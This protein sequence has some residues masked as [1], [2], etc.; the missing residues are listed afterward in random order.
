[1]KKLF[2]CVLVIAYTLQGCSK[3]DPQTEGNTTELSSEKEIL[4]FT[5]DNLEVILNG[6]EIEIKVPSYQKDFAFIPDYKI[7][8]KAT[9][10]P[11]PTSVDYTDPVN[12]TITAEDGTTQSYVTKIIFEKGLKNIKIKMNKSSAFDPTSIATKESIGIIDEQNKTISFFL[13]R[14][15][16]DHEN[17]TSFL[18]LDFEG[19]IVSQPTNGDEVNIQFNALVLTGEIS[20]TFDIKII[21]TENIF[22]TSLYTL[23]NNIQG[24]FNELGS[25]NL[26]LYQLSLIHI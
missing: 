17:T 5:I 1:M 15:F 13:E 6:S 18:E 10:T 20:N 9:I 23:G 25:C 3:S 2:Y 21:N 12:F 26:E 16:F 19:T 11:I 7:S 8:E 4:N 24:S 22:F 14:S